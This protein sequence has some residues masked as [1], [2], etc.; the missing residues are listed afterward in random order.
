[1]LEE[2]FRDKRRVLNASIKI[3]RRYRL[4]EKKRLAGLASTV[5]KC[6]S[7]RLGIALHKRL[8]GNDRHVTIAPNVPRLPSH[9]TCSNRSTLLNSSVLPTRWSALKSPTCKD[10][11][12]REPWPEPKR[13]A[14]CLC[15]ESR[16]STASCTGSSLM[17]SYYVTIELLQCG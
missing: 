3:S 8:L 13:P 15:F 6:G 17:A 1:M 4:S 16:F 12:R 10:L 5:N 2:G 7:G 9:T 14:P 11:L